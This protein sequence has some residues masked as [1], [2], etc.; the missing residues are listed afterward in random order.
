[1][2]FEIPE[3]GVTRFGEPQRGSGL[4]RDWRAKGYPVVA[5]ALDIVRLDR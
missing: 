2:T 3:A 4:I 5:G 1:M